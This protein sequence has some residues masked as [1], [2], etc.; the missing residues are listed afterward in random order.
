MTMQVPQRKT[1]PTFASVTI[2][3]A[4]L[5]SSFAFGTVVLILSCLINCVTIVRSIA[6][7]CELV[8]L[9]FR[10]DLR[11]L[12]LLLLLPP[13]LLFCFFAETP[14]SPTHEQKKRTTTKTPRLRKKKTQ[15]TSSPWS[16]CSEV[17]KHQCC[18][19]HAAAQPPT[20]HEQAHTRAHV[21]T[22]E[23]THTERARERERVQAASEKE[24]E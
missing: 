12:I 1:I 23:D 13:P 24:S 6:H 9:S 3:S 18:S 4:T 14:D 15:D 5:R 22:E 16:A 7:L 2:L 17:T 10:I 20:P 19:K 8:R 11:C 21:S